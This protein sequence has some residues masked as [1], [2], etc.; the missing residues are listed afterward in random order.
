MGAK[1]LTLTDRRI[2]EKLRNQGKSMTE[3]AEFLGVDYSTV[4]RELKRGM[5]IQ[6]NTDLTEEERYCAD[7]AEM[8]HRAAMQSK[9]L[10]K[11]IVGHPELANFL[12][13]KILED[14][15]SPKA[16]LRAAAQEH[17]EVTICATTLY[18]YIA[19][20]VFGSLTIEKLPYEGKRLLKRSKGKVRPIK[21]VKGVSIE[22]RDE[23]IE[24]REEFGHWE[25]D[26]VKGSKGTSYSMLVLTE[27]KTRYEMIFKIRH[28]AEEVVGIVDKLEREYGNRFQFVFKTVTSD[29]GTEF[30]YTE[31]LAQSVL[32]SGQRTKW[33]YAHPYSSWERG[34]NENA[35]KLI[36]RY[37][38]KGTSFD[39][40]PDEYFYMIQEWMNHYPR[41]VLE[42]NNA[43]D[44]FQSEIERITPT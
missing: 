41:E 12:E 38:P 33:Y 43:N 3:I 14:K 17:F 37:I 20:G 8:R 2:I 35:N 23:S 19:A 28:K 27:R 29:N 11:K 18:S 5:C 31:R 40:Y 9:G 7:F 36:R 10:E 25:M 22:K 42:W 16:A 39:D 32:Y 4:W 34:S 21:T 26:T 15:Y 13:K 1:H 44:L 30:S 6:R 24:N